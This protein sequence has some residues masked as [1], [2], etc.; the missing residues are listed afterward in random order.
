MKG[1][2]TQESPKD[3]TAPSGDIGA[4]EKD[5]VVPSKK[6][7]DTGKD[8]VE[9]NKDQD[10]EEEVDKGEQ[11]IDNIPVIMELD[12]PKDKGKIILSQI[13]NNLDKLLDIGQMSLEVQA[14]ASQDSVK[15]DNEDKKLIEMLVSILQKV[16]PKV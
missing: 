13:S 4:Q 15:S 12:T 3:D 9:K 14:Q 1:E 8:E 11:K 5:K 6:E 2:D 16:V 10:K 7:L